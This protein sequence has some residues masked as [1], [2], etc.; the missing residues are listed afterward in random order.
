MIKLGLADQLVNPPPDSFDVSRYDD[1]TTILEESYLQRHAATSPSSSQT[2]TSP[3][4][5]GDLS[6]RG[7]APSQDVLTVRNQAMA[8][9]IMAHVKMFMAH[10]FPIMPAVDGV[11]L[12][13]DAANIESLTP[14]RHALLLSLCAVTRIQLKLDQDESPDSDFSY[15]PVV[16]GEQISGVHFLAAAECARQQFS[17]V[18]NMSEDAILTSFF[19]FV[20]NGNLE[21]YNHA[22]FYLS[23]CISMALLLGY[24]RESLPPPPD[25]SLEQLNMRRKIFWLLFITER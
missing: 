14:S 18:D 19:L 24:D 21:K 4:H 23:Q 6:Q 2:A 11:Q 3:S 9:T 25:L 1:S 22:W 13:S 8:A 7:A 16:H 15:S 12:L 20:S 17:V 10:L 5:S